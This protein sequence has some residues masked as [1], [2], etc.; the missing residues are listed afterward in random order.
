MAV[1]S[2]ML[3]T[4]RS[5]PPQWPQ[6]FTSMLTKSPG[7][8]WNS[9]KAGPK[10]GGQDARSNTRLRRC[11][12][13]HRATALNG[14]A[15]VCR[16]LG[17]FRVG[18]RTFAAP[19]WRQLRAQLRVRRTNS[20]GANLNSRRLARRAKGRMPVVKTPWKRVRWARGGHQR[21][22]LG[23]DKSAGSPI[24][25]AAGRPQSGAQGCAPSIP[26]AQT[27]RASCRSSTAS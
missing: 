1:G 22:Q 21:R 5:V 10:G 3:A 15:M 16:R 23:A 20:P 2:S 8:I 11:A 17:R 26:P 6:A 7:A 14:S 25:T 27:P 4:I 24:W 12:K 13:G 18:G 19:G 9:R